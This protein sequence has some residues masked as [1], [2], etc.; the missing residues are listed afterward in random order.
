MFPLYQTSTHP[1]TVAQ[2]LGEE[3]TSFHMA[4]PAVDVAQLTSEQ[5]LALQTYTSVTDQ[6]LAAAIPLLQRSEWNVQVSIAV[7]I[8]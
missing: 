4:G 3:L 8:S 2:E 6:D 5:R 7:P 1:P